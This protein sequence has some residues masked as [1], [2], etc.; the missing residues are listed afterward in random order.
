MSTCIDCYGT[1]SIDPCATVGCI[2]TNYAK[3]I[4]Y[5]GPDLFCATGG[6]KTFNFTGVAVN[7]GTTTD[8][9]VSPTGGTGSGLSVKVTRTVGSLVYKV[10]VVAP[11][12]GYTI[13]DVLTVAGATIGGATTANNLT[14]AVLSLVPLISSPN[15]LDTV[16]ASLNARI[17]LATPSGLDYS[18]FTYGCLRVGGNLSSVGSSITSAQ[19]FIEASAAALCS[20]NT[21]VISVETPTFTVPGCVTGITSGSSTLGQVLTAYGTKLCTTTTSIDMTGVTN[22]PCI[23][24]A[25]TTKPSTAVVSDYINWITTNVCGMYTTHDAS[26]GAVTTA[27]ANLKTYISGGS[28][29]PASINT[30]CITGGSATSTLSAAAILFTSEICAINATLASIPASS[31]TLTWAT[32]FG[33]TPYY[34]YT[35]GFTNS[36]DTLANQLGKIVSTLGRLK[37]KLNSSDFVATSDSDGLNV[38]LAAGVRFA[39]SQLSSCSISSL[40]DVTTT[41]PGTY[42]SLFWNGSEFVNKELIF[43]SAGGTVGITR[44]DN[45]GN[46][47]INLESF[48]SSGVATAAT[49]TAGTLTNA[50]VAAS[51][52]FPSGSLPRVSKFGKTITIVGSLAVNASGAFAWAHGQS[53]IMATVPAGY[54]PLYL[55][56]FNVLILKYTTTSGTSSTVVYQGVCYINGSDLTVELNS[57]GSPISLTSGES[58]EIFIGGNSYAAI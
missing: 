14:I 35:F 28:A 17:C 19:Q 51:L 3:C 8:Y 26:I 54:L 50:S 24:Y 52:R 58:L 1:N 29:V 16:I 36:S 9:T 40:L 23:A 25:F 37:L 38:A 7:P 55:P 46:I 2:S 30:S 32:N 18:V 4:T 10:I 13:N 57:P 31:Y 34:G 21:R 33:S 53:L 44:T 15:N 45:V 12:T 5:S 48:G 11:G 39:C 47:T 27:A 49:L 6:V 56:V 41:S 43:T 42:H 22:N 20:L